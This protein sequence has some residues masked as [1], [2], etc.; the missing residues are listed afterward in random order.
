MLTGF[1]GQIP[2]CGTIALDQGGATRAGWTTSAFPA[3]CSKV[4]ISARIHD[5]RHTTVIR[6]LRK[7]RNLK[8]VQKLLGHTDIRTTAQFYTD[9]LVEDLRQAMAQ[10]SAGPARVEGSGTASCDAEPLGRAGAPLKSSKEEDTRRGS[11]ASQKG[12]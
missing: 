11:R 6:T 5:M 10:A 12:K 8:A 2:P 4:G 3:S 1:T 9:A 7:T